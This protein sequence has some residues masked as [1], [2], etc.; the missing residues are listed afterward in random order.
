M[1]LHKYLYDGEK[2]FG[3][4][5]GKCTQRMIRYIGGQDHKQ[6]YNVHKLSYWYNKTKDIEKAFI[7]VKVA[8]KF[9]KF[10]VDELLPESFNKENKER[11]EELR[12]E[13]LNTYPTGVSKTKGWVGE[14]NTK[15]GFW[16]WNGFSEKEAKEKVS[17]VQSAN[18]KKYT[19][20]RRENPEK[21][22]DVQPNQIGYWI[23]KGLSEEEAKLKVKER[24]AT[25]SLEKCIT[26]YGEEKGLEVFNKRQEKWQGTLNSKSQGEID[27]TNR[28]KSISKIYDSET[29]IEYIKRM[30]NI[31]LFLYQDDTDPYTFYVRKYR[32]NPYFR[33]SVPPDIYY[34]Y[35]INEKIRRFIDKKIMIKKIEHF[36]N[37]NTYVKTGYGSQL[38][39]E[40]GLLRSEA[41]ID[42]Y[43]FLKENNI[44][45]EIEK[46]YENSNMRDDFYLPQYDIHIE[47]AGMMQEKEYYDKMIT[48]KD[49]FNAIII[50]NKEYEKILQRIKI[51][52]RK[53]NIQRVI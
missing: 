37:K 47:I 16:I 2:D 20:K 26:K 23:K 24:Q 41:E 35:F 42:C 11:L 53:N 22:N 3:G 30:K 8:K 44:T 6:V 49:K 33:G 12:N 34:E 38:R 1:L 5:A 31:A 27:D 29:Y 40:E 25:F 28:M 15:K 45:F 36:Y 7:A 13:L 10:F 14:Q 50:E 48:K 51:E 9:K 17:S 52:N 39:V 19:K 21:Y 4:C 32:N 46:R 43:Y 18:G